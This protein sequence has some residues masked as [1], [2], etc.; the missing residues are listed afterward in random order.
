MSEPV[1][2]DAECCAHCKHTS[3]DFTFSDAVLCH[4]TNIW[5]LNTKTCQL[6]KRKSK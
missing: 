2:V 1:V 3:P 6:F 5:L 4:K